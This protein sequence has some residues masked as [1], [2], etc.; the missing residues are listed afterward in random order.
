MTAAENEQDRIE[1]EADEFFH[2][3]YG[4]KVNNSKFALVVHIKYRTGREWTRVFG[5]FDKRYQARS[6]KSKLIRHA[7]NVNGMEW[8][9]E[10]IR[11]QVTQYWELSN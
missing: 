9:V 10:N 11:F 8:V 2:N 4:M 1:K 6:F 3:Q 5:P 7:A